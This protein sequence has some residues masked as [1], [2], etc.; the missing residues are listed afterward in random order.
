MSNA[1]L[2]CIH[3]VIGN[4][5]HIFNISIQTYVG[6]ND[7]WMGI[8]AAAAFVIFS[9]TNRPKFYSP[10]QLIFGHDMILPIKH[11]VDW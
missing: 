5:V 11:T 8:L 1:V 3:Q 6:E 7:P 2:E 10:G 9:I 4:L